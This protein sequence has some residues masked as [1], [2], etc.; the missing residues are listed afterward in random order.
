MNKSLEALERLRNTL[1]AEGYWQDILQD[2]SIIEKELKEHEKY[3]YFIQEICRYVGLDNLFPYDNLEEIEKEIKTM[4]DNAHWYIA[5]KNQKALEIIK[6]K[7]V[8]IDV[9]VD[10]ENANDYNEFVSKSKDRH[11]TQE[12]YDLLKKVLL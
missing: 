6:R 2:V 12:E 10:S 3:K 1:L 4:A 7:V 8:L 11:L 9:L 5:N